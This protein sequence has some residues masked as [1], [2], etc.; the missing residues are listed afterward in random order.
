M[1]CIIVIFATLAITSPALA[2]DPYYSCR[3]SLLGKSFFDQCKLQI[4]LE[5]C[6]RN[7]SDD[8]DNLVLCRIRLA[9]EGDSPLEIAQRM[10]Q[11]REFEESKKLHRVQQQLECMQGLPTC[12]PEIAAQLHAEER[13]RQRDIE[14]KERCKPT[15]FTDSLGVVHLKYAQP[16]CGGKLLN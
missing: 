3:S 13:Q 8:P 16:D 7:F 5:S 4:D 10:N 11:I 12:R 9:V 15:E 1:R 6:E 2:F 14:F